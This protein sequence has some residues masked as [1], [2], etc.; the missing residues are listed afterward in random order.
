VLTSLV[1]YHS[2]S[3]I[4]LQLANKIFHYL[5]SSFPCAFITIADHLAQVSAL[6]LIFQYT[7]L[8]ASYRSPIMVVQVLNGQLQV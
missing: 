7:L 3:F 2:A 6:S 8:D 4:T 5:L 1:A